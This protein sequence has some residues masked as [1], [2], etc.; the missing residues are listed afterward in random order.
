MKVRE[1]VRIPRIAIVGTGQRS[2]KQ[3]QQELEDNGVVIEVV[4]DQERFLAEMQNGLD[5]DA[6]YLDIDENSDKDAEFIDKAYKT[7]EVPMVFSDHANWH[8]FT[9]LARRIAIK[10]F[11]SINSD[12]DQENADLKRQQLESQSDSQFQEEQDQQ[13]IKERTNPAADSD[14]IVWVLGAS[15]GGPEVVKEFLELIEQTPKACF[16]L[17]QHIGDGFTE[18]LAS[19][20]NRASNM[21]VIP[22]E[23]GTKIEDGVVI[24]APVEQRLM[25][26]PDGVIALAPEHRESLYKPCIDFVMQEVA[27]RYG[28]NSGTIIFS[29]MGDDG[30]I[31]C[32]SIKE[33]G[34]IVW[35]QDADTCAISSMPDCARA[36][37]AVSFSGTPEELGKKLIETLGVLD[38]PP[39][40]PGAVNS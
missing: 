21:K 16:I 13:K 2:Y 9:K 19:Q 35:A 14:Q 18:L 4:L 3:L 5:I 15:L 30:S 28:E 24:T 27:E 31:G 8:S 1:Y 11:K 38:T 40:L 10:L 22:A 6:I 20:L 37:G 34:G 32:V 17:A 12:L 39:E 33:Y 29:G 36:T 23:T 25:I 26:H 7:I